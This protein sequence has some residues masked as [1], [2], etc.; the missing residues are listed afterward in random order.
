MFTPASGSLSSHSKSDSKCDQALEA[1]VFAG[2]PEGAVEAIPPYKGGVG[3]QGG[4][5]KVERGE[6]KGEKKQTY[7]IAAD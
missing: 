1:A 4:R 5:K 6:R 2:L 7:F 3:R